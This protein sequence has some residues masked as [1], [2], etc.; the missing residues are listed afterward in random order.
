MASAACDAD[1]APP[2]QLMDGSAATAPHVFLSGVDRAIATKVE[3]VDVARL[4]EGSAAT[5]CL[6]R[7]GADAQTRSAV[8]RVGVNGESVTFR[9]ASG[10]SL[11]ACDNSAG[12][13]EPRDRW[14]GTAYGRLEGGRLTD[15]RLDLAMCT[16]ATGEPVAF[17]WV[18]PAADTAFVAVRQPGFVEVYEVAARLPVR[19]VTTGSSITV[20]ESTASFEISEHDRRG[21]LVRAYTLDARVAG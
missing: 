4:A 8:V 11:H 3:V 12:K 13:R 17:A 7:E 15:P 10:R 6:D 14:C 1:K 16:T 9:A 21:A 18:E 5:A 19:V 20:E 2:S